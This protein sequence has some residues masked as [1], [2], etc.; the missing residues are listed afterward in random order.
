MSSL[1]LTLTLI[2]TAIITT[3][4]VLG[5]RWIEKNK[6]KHPGIYKNKGIIAG[7]LW[8]LMQGGDLK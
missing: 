6:E 3:L 1:E 8:V 7:T 4:I 2:L 5:I